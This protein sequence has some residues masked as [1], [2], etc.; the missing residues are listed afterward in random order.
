MSPLSSLRA[1]AVLE[2]APPMVDLA[3]T[4]SGD[5]LQADYAPALEVAVCAAL[6]WLQE[7]ESS[8]IHAIRAPLTD[9]GLMLSHR[10]RLVLRIPAGR[11]D[12]ARQLEGQSLQ[13][14]GTR[15][16]V[17][18]PAR[19]AIEPFP[20]LQ[21]ALVL[22]DAPDEPAFLDDVA[23]RFEALGIRAKLICGKAGVMVDGVHGRRG[24]GLVVHEVPAAHSLYLQSRGLGPARRLGCGLFVHHKI[25]AGLDSDPD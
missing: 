25:I 15:L 16:A 20:T 14:G 6:P 3:F 13:V 2:A 19:R 22:S 10:S 1:P 23:F 8:G 5:R 11:I 17:G 21:A 7:D 12:A 4:L 24:F 9:F 18:A